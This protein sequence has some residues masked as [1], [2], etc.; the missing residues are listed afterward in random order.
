M[1]SCIFTLLTKL[2]NIFFWIKNYFSILFLL[3]VKSFAFS[4]NN[5]QNIDFENGTTEKW[6]T[7]GDVVLVSQ[8][9]TDP[10]GNFNLSLSGNYA[11]KLGNKD[12][13]NSQSPYYSAIKRNIVVNQSNKFLMYGY[14]I[15]LLG[16]E[17]STEDAAYVQLTIT[18]ANGDTLPCTQ[19]LVFAQSSV[20]NG[21]QLSNK[22][23][24][25]NLAGECCYPIFYQPWKLNAVDLSLYVGQ[26]LTFTLKSD[27]C[28]YD[29]DWGY[30]YVD[31][32]CGNN[33]MNT[34]F[35]CNA[36]AYRIETAPGYSS[37]TWTGPGIISGQ[38]TNTIL[39]NQDGEYTVS[40]PNSSVGCPNTVVSTDFDSK[41]VDL[42]RKTDFSYNRPACENDTTFFKNLSSANPN[43]ID[44]HWTFGD[45]TSSQLF[46]P[47]HIY[48]NAGTYSVSLTTLNSVGCVDSTENTI[49][50]DSIYHLNIGTDLEH[51]DDEKLKIS[52]SNSPNSTSFLWSTGSHENSIEVM[53][54]GQYWVKAL[55]MCAKSD[56]ISVIEN[57]AF[58][59]KTPNVFTPNEDSI[60]DFYFIQSEAAEFFQF[61]IFDRWG[62]VIFNTTDPNFQWNGRSNNQQFDDGTYFYKLTY[63]LV[64]QFE[65]Q[66]KSGF[67]TILR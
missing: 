47:S 6:N 12:L 44:Y 25:M 4:Q 42:E 14:A 43:I 1:K 54:A 48:P 65:N 60:N 19:Y 64:C 57:P 55:E 58:M 46:N 38:G 13:P 29:V 62:N 20:G 10:Y 52:I 53:E 15:V 22:P 33:L 37:Y 21:F 34:Y 67:L 41:I 18:N 26:T 8:Q 35:D 9:E 39:V 23:N 16:Y 30:A 50:I 7:I 27:W 36:D 61:T 17:H 49:K 31:F 40:I 32:F 5:C 56:T 11:V 45:G 66:N 28:R 51:C 63:R 3:L 24:E 2:N 59:G